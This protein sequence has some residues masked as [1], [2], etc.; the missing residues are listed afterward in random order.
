[1]RISAHN[2]LVFGAEIRKKQQQQKKKKTKKK[3][4][5]KKKQ[6]KNKIYLPPYGT[7]QYDI[8][9]NFNG[10]NTDGSLTMAYSN[11]FLSPYGIFLIA[12]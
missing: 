10:S 12:Q 6:K 7:T 1:M 3:T 11:S 2:Q 9:S 8:Q 5:K 4:K